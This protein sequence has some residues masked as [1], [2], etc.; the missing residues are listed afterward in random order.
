MKTR[1]ALGLFLLALTVAQGLIALARPA[2]AAAGFGIG[3]AV[4]SCSIVVLGGGLETRVATATLLG[5]LGAAA[6][7]TA[8]LA[9]LIRSAILKGSPTQEG[10]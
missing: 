3:V 10:P 4:L 8:L 2:R 6:G 5:S 9:G 1:T 7:L